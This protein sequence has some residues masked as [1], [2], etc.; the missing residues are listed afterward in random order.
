MEMRLR[1]SKGKKKQ[2]HIVLP[3]TNGKKLYSTETFTQKPAVWKNIAATMK[4]FGAKA[5]VIIQD[6]SLI[7][8]AVYKGRLVGNKVVLTPT[9][10]KL[11]K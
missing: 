4:F 5:P 9:N 7:E 2:F 3:S 1:I 6:D 10:L 8:P 11:K